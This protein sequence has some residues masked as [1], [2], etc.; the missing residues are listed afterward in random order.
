[1]QKA[2][3]EYR[4]VVGENSRAFEVFI[5]KVHGYIQLFVRKITPESSK[6]FHRSRT[7][8]GFIFGGRRRSHQRVVLANPHCLDS[9]GRILTCSYRFRSKRKVENQKQGIR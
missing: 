4:E 7:Q 5:K 3:S 9:E 6:N 2:K 8:D 1:M